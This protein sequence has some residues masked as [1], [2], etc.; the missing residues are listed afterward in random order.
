MRIILL[1]INILA[2]NIAVA[3]EKVSFEH[4]I[5]D[6]GAIEETG[7]RVS[8]SFTF[9]NSS[10]QPVVIHGARATCGCT[11]PSYS[12]KPIMGGESSTIEVTFDPLYRPG[13][14]V[15]EIYV[16]M[17]DRD[18]P[19][20]LKIMG[21]V[22][23]RELTIEERYPFK[24]GDRVRIGTLYATVRGVAS[25]ESV[26]TAVEYINM[27]DKGVE[28]EF[29]PKRSGDD[30][31][32]NYSRHLKVNQSVTMSLGY[33]SPTPLEPGEILRDTL[34]IYINGELANKSLY[35]IGRQTR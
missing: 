4:L 35:I 28:I 16:Y 20:E 13:R 12:R 5:W 15:K 2:I 22:N 17:S 26:M 9:V 34:D 31:I 19:I 6:F 32:V 3:R 8:H 24:I 33:H 29:I 10:D 1:I 18:E 23:E 11:E 7:G 25:G 14:F 27:S 21:V 30:L